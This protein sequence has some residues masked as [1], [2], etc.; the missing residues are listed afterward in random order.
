MIEW[1]EHMGRTGEN[2]CLL[3]RRLLEVTLVVF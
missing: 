2:V 3:G 1:T